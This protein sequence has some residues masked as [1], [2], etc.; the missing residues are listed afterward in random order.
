MAGAATA[1]QVYAIRRTVRWDR[2]TYA[3]Q[4]DGARRSVTQHGLDFVSFKGKWYVLYHTSANS[5]PAKLLRRSV[6]LMN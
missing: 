1:T 6:S 2:F 5:Q 3:G 4:G